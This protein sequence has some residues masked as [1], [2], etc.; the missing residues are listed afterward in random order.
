METSLRTYKLQIVK[1]NA[2]PIETDS[3]AFHR[4]DNNKPLELYWTLVIEIKSDPLSI[5]CAIENPY[6]ISVTSWRKFLEEGGLLDF[7]PRSGDA[8]LEIVKDVITMTA[9]SGQLGSFSNSVKIDADYLK[10]KLIEA[11]D[12]AI[13]RGYHFKTESS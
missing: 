10:P 1:V 11:I 8:K 5:K 4:K 12:L 6:S 9:S 2:T 7:D 3:N 13:A